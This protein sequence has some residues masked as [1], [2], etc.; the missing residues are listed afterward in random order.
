MR[1]IVITLFLE[2]GL[3]NFNESL[4]TQSNGVLGSKSDSSR[5]APLTDIFI[6]AIL[7]APA[8]TPNSC[9]GAD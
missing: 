5:S 7:A 4:S 8:A 6:F 2:Y 1:I 3:C 9:A